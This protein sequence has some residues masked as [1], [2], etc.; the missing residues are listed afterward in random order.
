M[1]SK[2]LRLLLI[3]S[4]KSNAV[5]GPQKLPSLCRVAV[6][7][8]AAILLMGLP[9]NNCHR[10]LA[11]MKG[12]SHR[13]SLLSESRNSRQALSALHPIPRGTIIIL[14]AHRKAL[15]PPEVPT[16]PFHFPGLSQNRFCDRI[17]SDNYFD[18]GR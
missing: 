5:R 7:F 10:E 9:D 13:P 4:Y 2:T 15:K 6:V 3:Q 17:Q 18:N 14:H 1:K 12:Y 11:N 8:C 16:L